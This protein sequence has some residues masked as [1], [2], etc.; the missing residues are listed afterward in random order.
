MNYA[1]N[2]PQRFKWADIESLIKRMKAACQTGKATI[3]GKSQAT[4]EGDITEAQFLEFLK[5]QVGMSHPEAICCAAFFFKKQELDFDELRRFN[6]VEDKNLTRLISADTCDTI[7]EDAK[8]DNQ[9]RNI[10]RIFQRVA[11]GFIDDQLAF[12]SICDSFMNE[13]HLLDRTGF[14]EA[15]TAAKYQSNI[16]YTHQDINKMVAY[17]FPRGDEGEKA[18]SN[19]EWL[20]TKAL[21][22]F[23]FPETKPW[24]AETS[25]TAST[26]KTVDGVTTT[27]Y[28]TVH[29]KNGLKT[30]TRRVVTE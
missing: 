13:L 22:E 21:Y 28:T 10:K 3:A 1:M 18:G 16:P 14:R 25:E 2:R 9:T 11:Q 15:L 5:G 30:T 27:T 23:L 7:L 17:F 29:T 26:S 4:A 6:Q 20:S 12:T 19:K 8:L 24:G